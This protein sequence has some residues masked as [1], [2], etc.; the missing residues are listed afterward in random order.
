M[1]QA[2]FWCSESTGAVKQEEQDLESSDVP[3]VFKEEQRGQ[4]VR[5]E[6][7]WAHW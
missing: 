3:D 5:M 2:M 7:I 1:C 4:C 6:H